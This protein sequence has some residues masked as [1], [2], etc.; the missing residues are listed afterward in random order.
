[1]IVD[2]HRTVVDGLSEL[3]AADD[4]GEVVGVAA[5]GR[6]ALEKARDLHPD[7]VLMDF[8]MAGMDGLE[9]GALIREEH[10]ETKI[11]I[12]SIHD[13]APNEERATHA[14]ISAW[15]TKDTPADLLKERVF[16]IGRKGHPENQGKGV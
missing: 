3:F 6:E 7:V 14:G 11:V 12:L 2:D 9:A 16:R 10:D 5:S 8:S 13:R 4:R 15:I 1:M